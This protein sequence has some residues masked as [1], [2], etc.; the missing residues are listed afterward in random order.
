M[1]KKWGMRWQT[2]ITH[3]IAFAATVVIGTLHLVRVEAIGGSENL[4]YVQPSV[5]AYPRTDNGNGGELTLSCSWQY[6]HRGNV[7]RSIELYRAD[8][9]NLA[10][11]EQMDPLDPIEH[12]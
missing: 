4:S 12:Q 7:N 3:L 6:Q 10:L 5:S 1:E 11:I 2:M 8:R 9:P